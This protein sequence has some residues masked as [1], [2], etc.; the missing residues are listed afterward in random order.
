VGQGWPLSRD[1][2][3]DDGALIGATR[4]AKSKTAEKHQRERF[5]PVTMTVIC[6]RACNTNHHVFVTLENCSVRNSLTLKVY[7]SAKIA[8]I[9]LYAL[10]LASCISSSSEIMVETNAKNKPPLPSQPENVVGE[11]TVGGE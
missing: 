7:R 8:A 11:P 3:G 5:H 4:E 6:L 1:I 2:G 10:T 9:G